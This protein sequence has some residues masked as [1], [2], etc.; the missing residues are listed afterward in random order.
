M[1]FLLSSMSVVC[2][3]TTLILKDGENATME[4]LKKRAKWDNYDY[5]CRGLILNGMPDPLF[6]IYQNVKYFKELQDSLEAKYMAEDASNLHMNMN[7]SIQVSC[8]IDKLPP[9][10]KDFKHILKHQKEELTLVELGS[11]LR[12]EE[13][14]RQDNDKP[15]GNNVVGP[16]VVNMVEHNNS[17]RAQGTVADGSSHRQKRESHIPC[18]VLSSGAGIPSRDGPG[19]RDAKTPDA[20]L[21]LAFSQQLE[22]LEEDGAESSGKRSRRYI[23]HER[24]LPEEKLRRD[25]FRDENTPPMYPEEYFRR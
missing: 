25:Y 4:Q 10:W 8:I 2:V 20:V 22:E 24:E 1:R 11:Y 14:L 9:Y 7:E 5:V 16:S 18:G 3:L 17:T 23:A 19:K 15:N 21:R 13:S 6:D 12:I